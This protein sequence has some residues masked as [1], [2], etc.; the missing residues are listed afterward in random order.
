MA[1]IDI[2]SNQW[3]EM[4]FDARNK[5]YGAYQLRALSSRRHLLSLLVAV[6][7]FIILVSA[8]IFLKNVINSKRESDTSV[9]M[10]D[11]INMSKPK[12]NKADEIK[13]IAQQQVQKVLR[14][15]IK[16]TPPVIKKDEEVKQEQ[17][18]KTQSEVI[19]TKAAISTVTYDKGTN[20]ATATMPTADQQIS[21]EGSDD[22]PFRVVEQ[23]PEFPGGLEALYKY[24]GKHME[25]PA[26][27]KRNNISGRVF[28][29]FVVSSNGK[30]KN[31]QI[32]KGVD[33]S[34]DQE[35]VRMISNMP[36]WIPGR[37][38]GKPVSVLFVLPV[39]FI[40]TD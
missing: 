26:S 36:D 22:H 37:Q 34:L 24:M 16:F 35:A 2:Y 29:Q 18:L 7:L 30:I 15:T 8:P 14:N 25:Y 10:L 9:R 11:V 21:G 4:I 27:A 32:L 39:T 13:D 5:D 40:L 20:D 31:V 33:T 6:S 28:V 12:E 19:D 3:C 38:N 17:E 1:K 23:Q